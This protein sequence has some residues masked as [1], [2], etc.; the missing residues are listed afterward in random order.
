[1]KN[2]VILIE[3]R[4]LVFHGGK[5]GPLPDDQMK[6]EDNSQDKD[7]KQ[8]QKRFITE[9]YK[10]LYENYQERIELQKIDP[11]NYLALI[12]KLMSDASKYKVPWQKRLALFMFRS[13]ALIVNGELIPL[14]KDLEKV[15]KKVE[16]R[17]LS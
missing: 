9:L 12:P 1:L 7:E 5:C 17:L 6:K 4:S 11:R 10:R 14:E 16:E 8:K 15:V 13:P 2:S 3:E